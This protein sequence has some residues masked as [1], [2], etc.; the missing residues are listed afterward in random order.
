M[1]FL[2]QH[3]SILSSVSLIIL[4]TFVF[5]HV[6]IYLLLQSCSYSSYVSEAKF[7]HGGDGSPPRAPFFCV[8]AGGEE[9]RGVKSKDIPDWITQA[10]QMQVFLQIFSPAPGSQIPSLYFPHVIVV[11]S[12]KR[13]Q[14]CIWSLP[15]KNIPR[16]PRAMQNF[17]LWKAKD[18][19][20]DD[21]VLPPCSSAFTWSQFATG[22]PSEREFSK[23]IMRKSHLLSC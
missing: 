18:Y 5:N 21:P 14:E 19:L 9:D 17:Q 2:A 15:F 13:S 20:Y 1:V 8:C 12:Q 4:H 23:L 16:I 10:T 6:G 11:C 22:S 7:L 3:T